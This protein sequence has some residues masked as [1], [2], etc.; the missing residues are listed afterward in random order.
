MLDEL[1]LKYLFIGILSSLIGVI[2]ISSILGS[3]ADQFRNNQKSLSMI[4]ATLSPK[5]FL[6]IMFFVLGIL[7]VFHGLEIV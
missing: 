7:F 6:A 3:S 1:T 4:K 5:S 2:S